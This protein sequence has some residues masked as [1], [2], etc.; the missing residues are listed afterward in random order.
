[1]AG[2]GSVSLID[3]SGLEFLINTDVTFATSSNASG[4]ANDAAYTGAVAATTTGGGTVNT[5]LDDAFN[6]YNSLFVNNVSYNLNGAA[7]LECEGRLVEF[8]EQTIGDLSV[9]RKVFV[10]SDDAFCRWLNIVTNEG[11]SDEDV[12]LLIVNNLGSDSNTVIAQS[13]LPPLAVTTADNWIVSHE[14]FVGGESTDP[15]LGHVLQG[16]N[17]ASGLSSITFTGGNGQPF[18]EYDL[19]LEPGDTAIV[20]NFVTGQPGI[21]DAIAKAQELEFVPET[22]L[23]CLTDTE[24]ANIVNFDVIEPTC[25]ITSTATNPTNLDTIPVKVTF[26]EP[27]T[28]FDKTDIVPT[29][30]TVK[31]FEGSGAEY[32]FNLKPLGDGVVSADIANGVAEDDGG[33]PNA[34][35][36]TFTRTV[37]IAGPTVSMSTTTPN[38]SNI[39]RIIDVTVTFS[40]PVD[41]FTSSDVSLVNCTLEGFSQASKAYT[42]FDL[43]LLPARIVGEV[44]ANI[45]AGV[46]TDEAG[47][48]NEAAAP[49]RHSVGPGF[50][51]LGSPP[52]KGQPI[53]AGIGEIAPLAAVILALAA[54]TVRRR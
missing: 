40:E 4:A 23:V 21:A 51:C 14:A 1:M 32:T 50:S 52:V 33:N 39:S 22:A 25:T 38:P 49:F 24:R 34:A 19:T 3:A 18:W 7:T 44:G 29:N 28:G 42:Q 13:A 15:R 31:K 48:P 45:A 36:E 53:Q 11:N 37:D 41:G 35:A 20:M 30:A 12:T 10:P 26:S 9:Q 2:V 27:V 46:A 43:R 5:A 17:R 16:P 8:P 54:A 6:G 47:N